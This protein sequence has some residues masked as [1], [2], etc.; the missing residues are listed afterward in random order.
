MGVPVWCT[1]E[2]KSVAWAPRTTLARATSRH[3]RISLRCLLRARA[4]S[5]VVHGTMCQRI[6]G[7]LCLRESPATSAK[8]DANARGF[9][10]W[11]SSRPNNIDTPSADDTAVDAYGPPALTAMN[12]SCTAVPRRAST[13]K[14]PGT[15]VVTRSWSPSAAQ[16]AVASRP[17]T[18]VCTPA[19]LATR[20]NTGMSPSTW[21]E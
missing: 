9:G 16:R 20:R 8:A 14:P 21:V 19:M 4:S 2:Q 13:L 11:S 10:S 17:G 3:R 15:R 6:S 1:G 18:T 5:G 7:R 12:T